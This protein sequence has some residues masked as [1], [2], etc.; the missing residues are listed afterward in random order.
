MQSPNGELTASGHASGSIYIFTNATG[1]LLHSLP[2]LVKPV[3]SVRFSPGSS[4][5]AAAGD[6]KIIALFDPASGDQ[7]ASLTGHQSWIFSLDW[8]YTG[9]YL[10]SAGWDGKVKVWNVETRQCVTTQSESDKTVW[11]CK[12]LPKVMGRSEGFATAGASRSIS[13]Y[14]EA[15][16]G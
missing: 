14:R 9:E 2:G 16:G 7:V 5:L 13:L 1:R 10:L 11:S 3:R 6:A 4:L 15:T 12:W 8:S